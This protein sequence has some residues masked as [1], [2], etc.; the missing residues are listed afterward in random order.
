MSQNAHCNVANTHDVGEIFEVD[1]DFFQVV[2]ATEKTVTVFPIE[3]EFVGMN[4]RQGWEYAYMPKRDCFIY[5]YPFWTE[6]QQANGK[7]CM[8]HNYSRDMDPVHDCIDVG[9]SYE[10]Y[11]W[12]GEPSIYDSYN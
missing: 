12:D 8:I 4:D 2:S 11:V 5:D 10:A 1:G 6:S 9:R 7:R 3:H